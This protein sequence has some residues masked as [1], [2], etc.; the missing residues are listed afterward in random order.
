MEDGSRGGSG[1][2]ALS[3]SLRGIFMLGSLLLDPV[4]EHEA[5]KGKLQGWEGQV[6]KM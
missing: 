6:Q 3:R 5:K 1:G 4:A 2:G